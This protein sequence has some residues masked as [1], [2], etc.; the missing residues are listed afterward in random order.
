VAQLHLA[1]SNGREVLSNIAI[2]GIGEGAKGIRKRHKQCLQEAT[3][4][5]DGSIGNDMQVGISSM[6][7]IM[8][9][10]GSIEHHA[11]SPMS[12]F[13]KLLDEACPN[14]A[15]PIQHK[16]R[17]CGMMKNFMASG[18]HRSSGLGLDEVTRGVELDE[19]PDE[20]DIMRF[21][22]RDVVMTI[23]DG[24]PLLGMRYVSNLSTG[25][26]AHCGWGCGDTGMCNTH[27][28]QE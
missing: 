19:V 3:T 1:P 22:G 13:E 10:T 18:C 27:F 9:V 16:L 7:R 28:L 4:A 6:V 11:R 26:P 2:Q 15:Y 20:G 23:Y 25:T 12:H 21:P 8:T 14:H 17:D 5:V 24:H